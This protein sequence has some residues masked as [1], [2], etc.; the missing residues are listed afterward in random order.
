MSFPF[1]EIPLGENSEEPQKGAENIN[2]ASQVVVNSS[3][4]LS[5]VNILTNIEIEKNGQLVGVES[6]LIRN[7]TDFIKDMD[8]IVSNIYN[9]CLY[10]LFNSMN[11]FFFY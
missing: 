7:F 9:E 4:T 1:T 10:V 8:S 6:E 2:F 5:L 11:V 3:A